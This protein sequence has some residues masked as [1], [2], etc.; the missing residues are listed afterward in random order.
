MLFFRS[1]DDVA[2]WCAARDVTPGPVV[3][4]AQLWGMA[5]AFYGSRLQPDGRRPQPDEIHDIF[6]GLGL[7]GPFW[8]LQAA[9]PG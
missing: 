3:T 9:R 8:D 2:A 5:T 4:L 1:E 7:R 6:A